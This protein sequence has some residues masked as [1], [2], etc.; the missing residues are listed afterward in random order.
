MINFIHIPKNGG[1]SIKEY[2]RKHKKINIMYHGH[3]AKISSLENQM[4]IIRD[5]Y[6]RFCSAVQYAIEKYNMSNI[7]KA[8]LN[9]PNHWAEAWADEDHPHH[10]LIINEVTN[11]KHCIDSNII[12][13]KYTYA[14]QSYWINEDK[15]RYVIPFENMESY[16]IEKYNKKIPHQ[17][18]SWS[19]TNWSLSK[20]SKKFIEKIYKKDFEFIEKYKQFHLGS[21]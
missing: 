21:I 1:S 15:I 3:N 20:K 12:D 6:T 13:L 11:V 8:G 10:E 7:L 16:F 14:P 17:N 2:L 5:P 4:I 19:H 9:T 18:S